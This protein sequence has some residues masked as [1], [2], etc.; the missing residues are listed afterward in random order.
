LP[1]GARARRSG[2]PA[3]R[4]GLESLE[5]RDVPAGAL[6]G[7]AISLPAAAK[8]GVSFAAT[9][10]AVDSSG[11]QVTSSNDS[12]SLAVNDGGHNMPAVSFTLTNGY[13]STTGSLPYAG[14]ASFTATGEGVT[15]AASSMTI[16]PPAA[17]YFVI[18]GVPKSLTV[19]NSAPVTI[20]ALDNYGNTANFNG[21]AKISIDVTSALHAPGTVTLQ[22][23]V[24]TFTITANESCA[25]LTITNVSLRVTTNS[26]S[27]AVSKIVTNPSEYNFQ[28]AIGV[29]ISGPNGYYYAQEA[30][31]NIMTDN[32]NDAIAQ[33]QSYYFS[34]NGFYGNEDPAKSGCLGPAN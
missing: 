22:N 5:A 2:R 31:F 7:F 6:A 33:A 15:G 21:T 25:F 23:G 14:T 10:T 24:G 34:A 8:A 29:Y 26:L 28:I 16:K 30:V 4:L 27:S 1:G 18:S 12:I 9:Y 13:L 3:V 32:L 17:S 20:T 19:G 11:Q